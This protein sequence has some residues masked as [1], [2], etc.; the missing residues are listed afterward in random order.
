MDTCFLKSGNTFRVTSKSALDMHEVLPAGNYVIKQDDR[1]DLFLESI[2]PFTFKGKQYGNLPTLGERIHTTFMDRDMSTGVMLTGEKGSGKSLLAKLVC[3][4][5]LAA[6]IPTIVINAPWCGDKFN[7]FITAIKQPAVVLFDEFEKVYDNEDQEKIL[8]LLDGVFPSKK[9]FII[10]CNDKWRVDSHMRNRPGR[11]YYMLDFTGLDAE[12][13]EEYC[14]ENLLAKYKKYTA[15]IKSVTSLFANFNFDMLKAV[16]EEIN[17]YGETPKEALKMLNVKP[18]FETGKDVRYT[19]EFTSTNKVGVSAQAEWTGNP[20]MSVVEIG[21]R[22]KVKREEEW[23]ATVF[24]TSDIKQIDPVT[25]S[26]VFVNENKDRVVL[27]RI[28]ETPID[29]YK[30]F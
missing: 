28:K 14:Q 12:F 26:Y 4:R 17:R 29:V 21:Y 30:A 27:T 11:I 5:A 10:T 24:K 18:Q 2:N 13:V 16:V 15:R 20:L 23:G 19:V 7:A 9:L 25:N 22:H 3:M 8:T 1:G 6:G